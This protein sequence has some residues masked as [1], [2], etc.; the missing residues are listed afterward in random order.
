MTRVEWSKTGNRLRI[1]YR[2]LL[3]ILTIAA[4]S[5]GPYRTFILQSHWYWVV[6]TTP[7]MAICHMSSL[8]AKWLDFVTY[9]INVYILQ[10]IN[11]RLSLPAD[12]RLPDSFLTRQATSPTLDGPLNRRLRRASLV[13]IR[14]RLRRYLC[15]NTYSQCTDQG[16][17]RVE[18]IYINVE[19]V[20]L[21][22]NSHLFS[23]T[24]NHGNMWTSN[25]GGKYFNI[26]G[27]RHH[28]NFWL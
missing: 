5:Q 8:P 6:M 12:L 25:T 16:N 14:I 23:K 19:I 7:T 11:K 3:L 4:S 24:F 13:R 9:G 18:S 20:K 10:D 27:K 22:S 28:T 21:L 17:R 1:G 26:K 2:Y 15:I